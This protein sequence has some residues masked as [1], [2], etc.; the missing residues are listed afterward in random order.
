MRRSAAKRLLLQFEE[1]VAEHWGAHLSDTREVP[2]VRAF[3][4]YLATR[5]CASRHGR[6]YQKPIRKTLLAHVDALAALLRSL[7]YPLQIGNETL[8]YARQLQDSFTTWRRGAF[9]ARADDLRQL[10]TSLD[11]T[12]PRQLRLKAIMLL[13][14]YTWAR[15]SEIIGRRF[16]EDLRTNHNDGIVLT[17]GRSKTNPNAPEFFKIRHETD[18]LLCAI[19]TLRLW[20]EW[21][22]EGYR[23]PLFPLLD[24]RNVV[25]PGAYTSNYFSQSLR[26]AFVNAGITRQRYTAYSLRK[27]RATGA[28]AVRIPLERI[29]HSLRHSELAQSIE[30]I[31]P[32]VLLENMRNALE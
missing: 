11:V 19:C 13:V 21:L 16:P 24:W 7:D 14:W 22:G 29:Q 31:D 27:G 25:V 9:P 15:P 17:V 32:E 1:Y 6:L 18:T 2:H 30:Y 23:G 10:A 8:R 28:A 5:P 26:R 20:L 4:E 12:R 3:I